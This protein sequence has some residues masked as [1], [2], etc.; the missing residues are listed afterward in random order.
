MFV[1]ASAIVAPLSTVVLPTVLHLA[2]NEVLGIR[3]WTAVLAYPAVFVFVP[4]IVYAL[5][6]RTFVWGG[7]RYRWRRKF[8]VTILD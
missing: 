2:V 3:R 7:R 1:L 8:D 6:R 4:L 5:A